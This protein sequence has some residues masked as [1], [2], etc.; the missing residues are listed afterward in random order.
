MAYLTRFSNLTVANQAN[1][2]TV[3]GVKIGGGLDGYLLSTDG[4]GNLSWETG[5]GGTPAG[6]DS[7]VQFNNAGAFGASENLTFDK[8]SG[9]LS[10]TN[11]DCSELFAAGGNA[12]ITGNW[13][14]TDNSTL[15]AT[16]ADLAERYAS[17]QQY[18]PG[19]VVMIGGESEVTI[20]DVS[21]RYKLA[22]VVSTNPAYVLNSSLQDSVI[23]AL[24]GRVPCKVVGRVNK[25]DLLT[26]SKIPGVARASAKYVS[27]TII[28]RALSNHDSDEQGIIEIK[29]G[30]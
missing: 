29:V 3:S 16:W 4:L 15:N 20:A 8:V 14:L 18:E 10:S 30:G 5:A 26:I 28:G 25:G 22:G 19:T 6:N 9:T 7:W 2:G 27:G 12:N 1:L 17:D 21:G 11:V 13:N 24:T 23:V